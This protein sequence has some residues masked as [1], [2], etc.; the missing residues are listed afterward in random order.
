MEILIFIVV[1][2]A[3]IVVHEFGHFVAAKLS[4][5][6][7]DEFGLGYPPRA[8][9]IA[10]KGETI[11]TLNWLPF[12]GFVKIYGED[13]KLPDTA[14]DPRSFSSRPRILQAL[15]LVAGVTMNLLFAYVLITSALIAGTPRALADAEVATAQQVELAV[16]NVLPDSPAAQAGLSPGDIILSA[17]DGHNVFSGT[18]PVA[19]TK[20]V[21][22]G[23]G[24]A[25]IALSVR[26]SGGK[27]TVL[28]ARP[29]TGVIASDPLRPALGVE[30]ATIGVV[31]LSFGA[32]VVEGAQLTWEATKLTAVGLWYFFS[33]VFTLSAD[34]SQVAGPVGI[35]GAVGAASLQGMGYLFSIM[36]IISIN[37]A[38]INLIP[39][40]AL[41]GG[42]LLFVIIE[43]IIRRPIKPAIA[44]GINTIGFVF[45][46]LLMVVVTA[47]DIFKIVG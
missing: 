8:L 34:L 40:P 47:H 36:A 24:N 30:V 9:T 38:L 19:F 20:F 13:G 27:E 18:D 37:L 4:G 23:G 25:T 15:V 39:V 28:F 45:L 16:A 31:P 10:K 3:L 6:R 46:I 43:G 41:D 26:H 11:Y 42:R 44:N 33:G 21:S 7:V 32:A 14:P 29:T 2:V 22:N 12:G 35:A 1:I 17:E 5:M